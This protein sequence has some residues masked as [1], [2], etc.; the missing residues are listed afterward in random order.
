MDWT[1]VRGPTFGTPAE[2][3]PLKIRNPRKRASH[4]SKA[5]DGEPSRSSEFCE[6]TVR[7]T[8]S[9]EPLPR[10]KIPGSSSLG[11]PYRNGALSGRGK[12][13]AWPALRT[14]GIRGE[15]ANNEQREELSSNGGDAPSAVRR[16]GGMSTP[17]GASHE[18]PVVRKR[19]F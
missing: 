1:P 8:C 9:S 18:D 10:S 6:W 11:T 2:V 5:S 3:P 15:R 19:W 12:M 14:N 7:R 17:R 13:R 4:L 16:G